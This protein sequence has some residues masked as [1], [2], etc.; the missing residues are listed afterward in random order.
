MDDFSQFLWFIFLCEFVSCEKLRMFFPSKRDLLT[1]AEFA[2]PILNL[3]HIL[4]GKNRARI[5]L[6]FIRAV[7]KLH[8]Y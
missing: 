5:E 1:N 7:S 8:L 6:V 3:E 2:H 4:R